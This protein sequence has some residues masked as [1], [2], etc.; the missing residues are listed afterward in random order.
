[1]KLLDWITEACW[2]GLRRAMGLLHVDGINLPL[3]QNGELVGV[4]RDKVLLCEVAQL[5][6]GDTSGGR[7]WRLI[8]QLPLACCPSRAKQLGRR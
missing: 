4:L 5:S 7:R 1:M 2:S 3:L 6:H 8:R